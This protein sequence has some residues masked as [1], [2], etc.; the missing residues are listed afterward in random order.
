MLMLLIAGASW[1]EFINLRTDTLFGC[2][3]WLIWTIFLWGIVLVT[4]FSGVR[5][6]YCHRSLLA[7]HHV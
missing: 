5:Y 2:R 4:V 1:N 7:K 6:F 3:Y